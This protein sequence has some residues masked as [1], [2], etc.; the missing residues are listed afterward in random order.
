[1]CLKLLLGARNQILAHDRTQERARTHRAELE[2][3]HLVAGQ[4]HLGDWIVDDH[5]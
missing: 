4:S 3:T 2:Q 1:M 5:T